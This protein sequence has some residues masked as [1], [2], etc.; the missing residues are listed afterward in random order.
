ML[1]KKPFMSLVLLGESVNIW[2]VNH[3][4]HEIG[5]STSTQLSRLYSG[6]TV[7]Y[8]PSPEKRRKKCRSK[9]VS[10]TGVD[11]WDRVG[12]GVLSKEMSM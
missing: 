4:D 7:V 10:F 11:E 8:V 12:F 3:Q 6:Y 1:G 5:K 9:N 2:L